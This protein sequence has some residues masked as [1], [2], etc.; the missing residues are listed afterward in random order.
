MGVIDFIKVLIDIN[1]D[2]FI[3]LFNL[4]TST[5]IKL[6]NTSNRIELMSKFIFFD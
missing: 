6:A 3:Q 2:A 4:D 1:D 5:I